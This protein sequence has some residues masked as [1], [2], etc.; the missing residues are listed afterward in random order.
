[1]STKTL[2]IVAGVLYAATF[3]LLAVVGN[4]DATLDAGGTINEPINRMPFIPMAV[5][6]AFAFL[7]ASGIV[8]VTA[9]RGLIRALRAPQA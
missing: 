8:A 3:T 2:L 9:L 6:A 4:A 1:V 5:V 7:I